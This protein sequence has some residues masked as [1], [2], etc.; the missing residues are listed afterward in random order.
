M[1]FP[2]SPVNGQTTTTNNINYVYNST[3][4]VWNRVATTITLSSGT[5]GGTAASGTGTTTT[6]VISNTT[7]STSTNSGALQVWGGAGV[8]GNLNVGGNIVGGGVRAT[9]TSTAPVN[10]TVGDIWYQQGTDIVYRYEY[11]GSNSYWI[12]ITSP[13]LVLTTGTVS[14]GGGGTT[15]TGGT[16]AN[17]TTFSTT[18]TVVGSLLPGANITYDLGSTSTRWRTLY[19]SSSTIDLGGVLISATP[20]GLSVGGASVVVAATGTATTSITSNL[21]IG[22]GTTT[23]TTVGLAVLTNDAVQL[24]VG[25]TAQRPSNPGIGMIR[26]NTSGTLGLE[27]FVS[28]AGTG[29]NPSIG[30]WT[31][32]V[33]PIYTVNYLI[34]AGGGGGGETIGGGGGAGGM[35]TGTTTLI[36]GVQY[37][38]VVGGGGTGDPALGNPSYATDYGGNGGNTT[39]LGYA[40]FGGG[41][42]GGYNSGTNNA[43]SGGSGGGTGASASGNAAGTPGQG[44]QGGS[45]GSNT[46]SGAGGGG[47]GAAGGNAVSGTEGTGGIGKL[48]AIYSGT[49]VYYAGG[50][51]GGSRF[52]SPTTGGGGG[53]GGLG[54]GGAGQNGNGINGTAYT[55]GGGG[56][57]GYANPVTSYAGANGGSGIVIISYANASQRAS[58]G[59]VTSYQSGSNLMWVHTFT[60]SSVF[61]A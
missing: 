60:T 40:A 10:P 20:S 2:S 42:G 57:G 46:N 48:S 55:G 13:V 12:D 39:A 5:I 49:N 9:T 45:A 17:A 6:F 15:F 4:G 11:D 21:I 36:A 16:V 3:L 28:A 22:T 31:S 44:N 18:L 7:Q 54:G 29:T 43:Q 27:V 33:A 19:V 30:T 59:A 38:I 35:I 32:I 1:T 51:G 41:G 53:A 50:G 8:G 23:A 34:V 61:T 14:A 24:P 58:G 56:G 37:P 52:N 26:Y 25:T 47:A